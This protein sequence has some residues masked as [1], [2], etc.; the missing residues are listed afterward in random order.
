MHAYVLN[1]I[2]SSTNSRGGGKTREREKHGNRASFDLIML[3]E[4]RFLYAIYKLSIF[5]GEHDFRHRR[6]VTYNLVYLTIVSM[7]GV[8]RQ[9]SVILTLYPHSFLYKRLIKVSYF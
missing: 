9:S 8:T 3:M 6:F 4:M 7:N 1:R 5:F 2:S